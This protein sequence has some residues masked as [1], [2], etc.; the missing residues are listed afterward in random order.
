VANPPLPIEALARAYGP[1]PN[2]EPPGGWEEA[3]RRPPDRLVKTHCSFCGMQ[4]GIKLLVKNNHIVGFEPWEEFPFNE[5]RLCPK[6]VQRYLQNDHPDRLLN[7][8][9]AGSRD[10]LDELTDPFGV[11]VRSLPRRP[12]LDLEISLFGQ[13]RD[14]F[15]ERRPQL[16]A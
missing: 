14:A 15:S 1:H 4:C 9:V 2:Y 7:S 5:G 12:R 10:D 13:K 3:A 11:L 8:D 6:G 16:G